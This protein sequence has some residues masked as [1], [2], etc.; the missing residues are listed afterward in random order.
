[1]LRS[2]LN[3]LASAAASA[4]GS[5]GTVVGVRDATEEPPYDVIDLVNGAEVRRYGQRL[6]AEVSV[7]G[8]EV[9]ARGS[10]FR[11]LAAYISGAN[12]A[13][14][15]VAMTAPVAQARGEAG[16]WSIRFFMPAWRW[17]R[18]PARCC[19]SA[20]PTAPM[21]SPPSRP[22]F[23][24]RSRPGHGRPRARLRRGSTTR[25]GRCRR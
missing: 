11:L 12:A 3:R 24:P 10:G 2:A 20:A 15:K 17:W 25:P 1:M 4:L 9:E 19:A 14:E 8:D 23:S 18:K 5:A 6:A 13:R 16:Q 7:A 22:A 21:S